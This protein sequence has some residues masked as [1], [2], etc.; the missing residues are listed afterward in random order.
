MCINF[1]KSNNYLLVIHFFYPP[2][3]TAKFGGTVAIGNGVIQL[4]FN[5][6]GHLSNWTHVPTGKVHRL[7]QQYVQRHEKA[8]LDEEN[9]CDG[10]N[11]YTYVP[12]D[13][14]SVLSPKVYTINNLV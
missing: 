5:S 12:D 10:T 6:T 9:V 3:F 7:E 11:V 8:G 4:A 2:M 14:S 13:G 1:D